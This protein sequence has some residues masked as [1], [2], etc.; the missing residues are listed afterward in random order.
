LG[1]IEQYAFRSALVDALIRDI[2]GPTS[3]TEELTDPPIT[4]YISG[5]LYPQ[6]DPVE[7][8]IERVDADQDVDE[9]DDY[10]EAS[11]PDP[12]VAMANVKY[13]SSMGLTFAVNTRVTT[14]IRIQVSAGR[15]EP[16]GE[17]EERVGHARRR[18]SVHN[19]NWR[20]IPLRM[21]P[22][23]LDVGEPRSKQVVLSEGLELYWRVR[24]AD[25]D[26][27]AAV[28]VALINTKRSSGA[29][30]D[31]HA[32]FQPSI[33]IDV[34]SAAR[35]AFSDRAAVHRV[36]SDDD[37]RLYKLLY[38]RSG[39]YAVG[40]GCSTDWDM[41]VGA[42]GGR[43]WTE[44]VPRAAVAL[45]DSNPDIKLECLDMH[46]LATSAEPALT[47]SLRVLADGYGGW[48]ASREAEVAALP[49][50][51]QSTASA[52]LRLCRDALLRIEAGID[53]LRI[54]PQALR[55]F[56]LANLAMRNQ[57]SRTEWFAAGRQGAEPDE[58]KSFAWRPFQL[59]FLLLCVRG[60][61][62]P[63]SEERNV[64]DLLWFPTGGGKTEAYLGLIAFTVFLRRLRNPSASGVTALMR[65]TLRLL[66]TQQFERASMLICACEVLRRDT[67]SGLGD[68]PISIGLWVGQDATPNTLKVAR[69]SL[70]KLR[71]N[72]S[73][74]K[75]N[76][77]QLHS[78]PWCGVPLD[79]RNYYIAADGS[80]LVI[81]C[82]NKSCSFKGGLPIYVVDQDVYSHRPSLLI[83]TADKFASL[84]WREEAAELF[85]VDSGAAPPELIIQ[86]ELHLI[87]GPLG[88]LAGLYETAID[89]MCSQAGVR[90]K[91][92]AS[93]A[94]IR[95][96][97]EQA[98]A[99]FDRE[100]KQFPP[101]G[102]D[103]GDSYFARE[104]PPEKK[105]D[106]LYVGV[107]A[108]GTSQTTLLVR[109]YAALL[110]RVADLPGTDSAKDP[111][112]TLIG[113]FNS[114]RV[115][116]GA[117]MQVQDDVNDRMTLLATPQTVRSIEQR[118]E[119]TSRESSGDIPQHLKRMSVE[120]PDRY[121][122]DVILATNMISVGMDINRLGL[123]VVMGQPQS[124]SEYIQATSRVGRQHP[125]LVVT[126][127]NAARS[128]DRSHYESFPG[129]H[130]ALYRQVE[131]TSVTPYSPRARDRAL[132]AVVV[133]LARL[134]IPALRPNDAATRVADH[135]V[136]LGA[137][138]KSILQRVASISATD[139]DATSAQL[140]AIVD[141]WV[142]RARAVP[143]LVYRNDRDPGLSLLVTASDDESDEAAVRTLW[144]LRDVD[145]SSHLY[146]VS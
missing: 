46:F 3:E 107:M 115:L 39:P 78:C 124:T 74:E 53:W 9:P 99:L 146:P 23:S 37:L 7:H 61:A 65:Y 54:D 118:I 102:L 43:I 122:L 85:N 25:G 24:R 108:A 131:S 116:G 114:L 73:L 55:A 11:L 31:A 141:Q 15:Y 117:R 119:L 66:T 113:Y 42:G 57:R 49:A 127:F 1:L 22:T 20:R 120:L 60:I 47:N 109:V 98:R 94:T 104:L 29:Q 18:R 4:Q 27:V 70:D 96:A 44:V 12:P 69:I 63:G 81:D 26:G 68:D 125:G 28:T 110:Q 5:V 8:E 16:H 38:R 100:V 71:T 144:S 84:P 89:L 36:G 105:G 86:D 140:D 50:A 41:S 134:S 88:T 59:A 19:A 101:A 106:R 123:M 58:S 30:R 64:A 75:G 90:P 129:Y 77:V 52:N 126:L 145:K 133:A 48:I 51:L 93:T 79:H 13:P 45:S 111:Y 87:S 80:R 62:D 32:F 143:G 97:A 139:T 2:V 33:S 35:L 82:Q 95:R 21:S 83:A 135:L 14:S 130:A 56:Q 34:P 72:P 40:H 142:A 121:T 137:V 17:I 91:L 67:N 138:K 132:H 92:I 128:R 103:A 10:D 112:W 136:A 76:P 6:S